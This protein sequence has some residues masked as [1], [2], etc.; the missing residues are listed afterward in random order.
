VASRFGCEH[1]RPWAGR[2]CCQCAAQAFFL[3]SSD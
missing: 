1:D 3:S 2:F